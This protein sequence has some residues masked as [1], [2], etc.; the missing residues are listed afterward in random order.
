MSHPTSGTAVTNTGIAGARTATG[1]DTIS[2]QGHTA[3]LPDSERE[4][5]LGGRGLSTETDSHGG[6]SPVN[7][8]PRPSEPK[9]ECMACK[10]FKPASKFTKRQGMKRRP[11]R[12]DDCNGGQA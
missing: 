2:Q 1:D 12:C 3:P 8:G 5:K 9:H 6:L 10:Q 11:R 4:P 7:S